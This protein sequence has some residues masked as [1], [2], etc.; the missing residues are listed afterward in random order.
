MERERKGEG[1]EAWVSEWKGEKRC[2]FHVLT[3]PLYISSQPQMSVRTFFEQRCRSVCTGPVRGHLDF[4][5]L[6]L[7]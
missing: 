5:L 3:W 7:L 6:C 2:D 4:T 1:E